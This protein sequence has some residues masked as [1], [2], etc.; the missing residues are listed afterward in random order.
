MDLFCAMSRSLKI[1]FAPFV[2]LIHET[3]KQMKR[4]SI[5]FNKKIE[6]TTKINLVDLFKENLEISTKHADCDDECEDEML[7][8][9][10]LTQQ[11]NIL[12]S[13]RSS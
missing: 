6:E 5:E 8:F 4:Q 7:L 1:D 10:D 2:K 3:L 13:N 9:H 12:N 11:A